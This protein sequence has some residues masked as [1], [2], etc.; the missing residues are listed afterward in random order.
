[1]DGWNTSFL[2]GSG[3]FSGAKLLV[4][5]RVLDF[6]HPLH[7]DTTAFQKILSLSTDVDLDIV[8]V[9]ERKIPLDLGSYNGAHFLECFLLLFSL[10]ILV[11]LKGVFGGFSDF[12][13]G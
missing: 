7:Q 2:L 13:E 6:K 4:S 5:G 9:G 10:F 3:L 12:P 8:Q 1:M 11:F